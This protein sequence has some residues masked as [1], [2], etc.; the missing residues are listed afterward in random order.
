MKKL[1]KFII[2]IFILFD[3]YLLGKILFDGKNVQIFNPQ[4]PIALQE[5]SLIILAVAIM[6]IGVIPVFILAYVVASKY[7]E[8]NKKAAYTPDWDHSTSLQIFFWVFLISI[9]SLLSVVTWVSAHQL[10]PHKQI[11][12]EYKPMVIQVVA[13][14]WKWLFIYPEQGVASVNTVVFPEKTPVTF[15][16]TA[17]NSPMNSFWI[18]QLGG[19][20]YA[21]SGMA[22]ETH[23]MADG[24]GIYRGSSSE[25]SG[26]GFADMRFTA[27]SVSQTDFTNWVSKVKMYP[28]T[29]NDESFDQL[30]KPGEVS[31]PSYF[32][33]TENKLYNTIVM[34]YMYMPT[35]ASSSESSNGMQS[36]PNMQM[37]N[38]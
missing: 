7:R 35:P 23:L 20:I 17:Y 6:L 5:R 28:Q 21:M 31:Q 2:F 16:I 33:S 30:A 3:V 29:L 37:G 25:I 18:P 10:D 26:A 14:Q 19:Q 22:T 8:G 24:I 11:Y 15:E 27:Q 13:L 34:K 9:M 12:G 32:S 4:G 36:M 1:S 38:N